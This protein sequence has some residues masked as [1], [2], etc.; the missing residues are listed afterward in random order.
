MDRR[1]G[2]DRFCDRIGPDVYFGLL[3]SEAAE[4][5]GDEDGYHKWKVKNEK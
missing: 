4:G 2:F 1:Q 5:S 3:S